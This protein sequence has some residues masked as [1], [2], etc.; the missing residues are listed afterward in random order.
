VRDSLCCLAFLTVAM[1]V[2]VGS[3]REEALETVIVLPTGVRDFAGRFALGTA[4][5]FQKRKI[6]SKALVL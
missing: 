5:I 2:G 1:V 4:L 6:A 3:S